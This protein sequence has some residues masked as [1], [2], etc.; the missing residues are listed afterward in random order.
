MFSKEEQ[1][2]QTEINQIYILGHNIDFDIQNAHNTPA[3]GTGGS[4]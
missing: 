2:A 1:I 4:H 3:H